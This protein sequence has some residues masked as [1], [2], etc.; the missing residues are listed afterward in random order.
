[1]IKKHSDDPSVTDAAAKALDIIT[2]TLTNLPKAE[3][4]DYGGHRLHIGEYDVCGQCTTPIAEAQTA[5]QAL[6]AAAHNLDDET[7]KEHLILA[8]DLLKVESQAAVVRA[9]LHNGHGTE[10]ILDKL[11]AYQYERGIG[12]SYQHSHHGGD[13]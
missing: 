4:F 13:A 3:S 10:G 9:E 7:I 2:Q 5:E 11:L 1:M 8:A 12:D 6:R